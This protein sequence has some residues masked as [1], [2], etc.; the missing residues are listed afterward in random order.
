MNTLLLVT[1]VLESGTGAALLVAPSAV[2]WLL[3]GASLESA[4]GLL[5]AR[6]AGSALS[7]L[8]VACGLMSVDKQ[9]PAAIALIVPMLGYNVAVAGLLV[10]ARAVLDLSGIGLW[11]AVV[12]HTGLAVWCVWCLTRANSHP[13]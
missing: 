2:A 1:A 4:A 12:L 8:G 5:V 9:G 3:V 10:Y 13:N 6:V 7:A 11:P